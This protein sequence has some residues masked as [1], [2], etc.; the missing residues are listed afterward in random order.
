V[1]VF[2]E[3]EEVDGLG[4]EEAVG[5]EQLAGV[6]ETDFGAVDQAMGFA[7]GADRFG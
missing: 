5:A 7:Q 2:E 3:A 1:L 4:N 6:F